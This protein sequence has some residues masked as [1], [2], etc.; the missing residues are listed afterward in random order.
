MSTP[1]LFN[2]SFSVYRPKTPLAPIVRSHP[3][4][5]SAAMPKRQAED[6]ATSDMLRSLIG[7]VPDGASPN[8]LR[9]AIEVLRG[10]LKGVEGKWRVKVSPIHV[11][12][13]GIGI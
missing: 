10:I 4:Y 13:V 12:Y 9:E 11:A 5:L 7:A 8:D 1:G 3:T 2:H 6:L